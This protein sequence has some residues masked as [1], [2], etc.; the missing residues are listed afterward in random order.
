[1]EYPIDEN[2]HGSIR[3]NTAKFSD[4][5][6][7]RNGKR[8]FSANKTGMLRRA[9]AEPKGRQAKH[10]YSREELYDMNLDLKNQLN[11]FKSQNVRLST[12]VKILEREAKK[13]DADTDSRGHLV[14]NL[15][16]Q[17]K[18]LQRKL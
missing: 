16:V 1:M 17:V 2:H 6:A 4:L 18:E 7:L 12:K 14:H 3:P 13:D 10:P 15:K 9:K 5:K 8:P 11:Y